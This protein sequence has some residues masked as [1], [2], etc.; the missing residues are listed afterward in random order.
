MNHKHNFPVNSGQNNLP[1][2]TEQ[3]P[4]QQ[5]QHL[6]ATALY[7]AH[8]DDADAIVANR[9]DDNGGM[10]K[11]PYVCLCVLGDIHGMLMLWRAS[12]DE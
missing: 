2:D 9:D 3:L 7:F 12:D 10:P 6:D 8:C 5:Q 11:L 4:Q 1:T